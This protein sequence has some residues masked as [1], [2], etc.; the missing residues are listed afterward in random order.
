MNEIN[1]LQFKPTNISKYKP[2][3]FNFGQNNFNDFSKENIYNS[4]FNDFLEK[5]LHI[6]KWNNLPDN[7]S[8][9]NIELTLL[10]Q[11]YITFFKLE[12]K[13]YATFGAMIPP[14]NYEYLGTKILVVNPYIKDNYQQEY[15]IGE[16]C[17]VIRNNDLFRGV[18]DT[19]HTYISIIT[20]L[21]TTLRI[22]SINSRIQF[23]IDTDSD[24]Q[25]E[26]NE[27]FIKAIK[28]GEILGIFARNTFF[29]GIHSNPFN[30]DHVYYKETLEAI[31]YY[32]AK[33]YNEFGIQANYNM[34][35]EAIN[36]SE[37]SA[38]EDILIP[39]IYNMLECRKKACEEINKLYGLNISVE[40]NQIWKNNLKMN[41][42]KIKFENAKIEDLQEKPIKEG[43]TNE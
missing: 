17:C 28:N 10:K 31:Q 26:D 4:L 21:Y 2:V 7:V 9:R 38:N 24:Q 33:L 43:V 14:L 23:I 25:K 22:T 34:K 19:I 8:E 20:E 5:I 12:D 11:G 6:F 1:K 13:Y 41:E 42:N 29:E 15:T 27:R 30:S 37:I 18:Y 40:L 16:D 36:S 39:K 32:T 3:D 35:R